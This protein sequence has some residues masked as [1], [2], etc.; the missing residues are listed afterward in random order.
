MITHKDIVFVV[1]FSTILF[2]S[3]VIF[4]I[5]KNHISAINE[6]KHLTQENIDFKNENCSLKNANIELEK[7]TIYLG[8]KLQLHDSIDRLRFLIKDRDVTVR[9]KANH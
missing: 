5:G 7:K 1:L 9:Q 3:I 6:T 2:M 4:I 8:K